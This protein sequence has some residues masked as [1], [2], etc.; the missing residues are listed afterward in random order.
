MGSL[1]FLLARLCISLAD[2]I[3]RVN[4]DQGSLILKVNPGWVALLD[5]RLHQVMGYCTHSVAL[6]DI[7]LA[8][9]FGRPI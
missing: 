8:Q 6:Q 1:K 5:I 7:M 2:N 4:S 9:K 3:L